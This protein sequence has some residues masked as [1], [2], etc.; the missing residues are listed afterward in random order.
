MI[1]AVIEINFVIVFILLRD[2]AIIDLVSTTSAP[3]GA[4]GFVDLFTYL[5]SLVQQYQSSD[6]LNDCCYEAYP[7]FR[8]HLVPSFLHVMYIL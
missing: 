2:Y 4:D 6:Q 5:L 1:R 3:F 8:L 7:F